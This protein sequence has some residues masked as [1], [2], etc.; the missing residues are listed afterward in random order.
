MMQQLLP[1]AIRYVSEKLARYAKTRLC[2]FFNAICAKMVDISKLDK[3]E[4][5]VV[6]TLCLLE[7]YF[8]PSFFDI[9]VH[10]VVHLV[11]EVHLCG[12]IYFRWM[13]R[14]EGYMKVLNGYVQN[15]TR[16]EGCI[17]EWYIAEEAVEFFTKH[18]SNSCLI[19]RNICSTS[20][21]L[22]QNLEREQSGCKVSTI[23]LSFNG[24]ALRFI[25]N[26]MGKR[27]TAYHKI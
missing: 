12:P 9:M 25:V 5:D 26:L 14:F 6:L 3:L 15:R 10:L 4:E 20:R 23:A 27:I 18:L 11:R 24:Y 16:P 8:P 22:I 13:Y 21:P 2:F 19:S 1:V 7:K 17:A